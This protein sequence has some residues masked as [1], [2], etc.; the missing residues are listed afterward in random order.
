MGWLNIGFVVVL[1][2]VCGLWFVWVDGVGVR[3][4]LWSGVRMW[5]GV[6]FRLFG[7]WWFLSDSVYLLDWWLTKFTCLLGL[8][9]VVRHRFWVFDFAPRVWVACGL[10]GLR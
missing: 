2:F 6:W 7:V 1:G 3:W 9:G 5:V 8:R 10:D 4:V